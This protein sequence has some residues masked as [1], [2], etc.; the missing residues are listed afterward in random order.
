MMASVISNAQLSTLIGMI[1]DAAIDPLC[2]PT[3]MEAIRIELDGH[4]AT[5]DL[6][7]LP[8]GDVI[9]SACCNVP[10][11]YAHLIQ[12]AGADV[13]EQWGGSA[14]LAGLP[15][16]QPAVLSDVNP[17]FDPRTSTNGYFVAFAKPQQI[18]DVI[19]IPLARDPR[20]VG[21]LSFGRHESK[22]PIGA[23]E[24]A[25]AR[26]LLP[27]LQRAATI[28]RMLD[29]A[30][31]ARRSFEATL[32]ALSVPV[33]LVEQDAHVVYANLA[34]RD[35]LPRRDP[36]RLTDGKLDAFAVGPSNALAAA[37]RC[38][39]KGEWAIGRRGLGIPLR[40]GDGASAALH[41][42]PLRPG[43]RGGETGAIAAVFVASADTPFIAPTDVVAALFD[44]TPAEAR[45]F[46]YLVTKHTLARSAA[47]LGIKRST[48]KTHLQ[49]VYQKIGV[50]SQTDLIHVAASLTVPVFI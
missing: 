50:R 30:R 14:T 33:M 17:A 19:V 1:Y 32:D 49:S 28:N 8:S 4:N 7:Q 36:I 31:G 23:R 22:G 3:A 37:I 18:I 26:L 48:A 47:E 9:N 13:V 44:L 16:D 21:G 15:M 12:D 5:L 27:H 24:L 29:E 39:A 38:A 20:A 43:R 10:A 11:E 34:A 46:Q 25:V 41:V 45:V 40:G 6:L 35:L 42:L 2:W